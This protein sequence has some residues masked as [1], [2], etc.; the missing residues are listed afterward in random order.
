MA[1][2]GDAVVTSG[3]D[4]S[5]Y[6]ANIPVGEV[7]SQQD[8]NDLTEQSLLIEPYADLDGLSYVAVLLCTDDCS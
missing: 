7:V 8:T 5:T 3:L 2:R 1:E 4:R 6:P